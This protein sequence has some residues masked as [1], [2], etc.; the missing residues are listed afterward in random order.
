MDLGLA[1][2]EALIPPAAPKASAAPVAEHFAAEG[3]DV[4]VTLETRP[5]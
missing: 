3:V 4:A 5:A 2:I 1:G